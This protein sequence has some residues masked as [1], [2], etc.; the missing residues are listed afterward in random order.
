MYV[1][2]I[3][4]NCVKPLLQFLRF[5]NFITI[6]AI[7][8]EREFLLEMEINVTTESV[9]SLSSFNI[10]NTHHTVVVEVPI[11]SI[12]I[13]PKICPPAEVFCQSM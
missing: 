13:V 7:K 9:P 4:Y 6:N 8:L 2:D 12:S 11:C 3:I 5:V 10:Y 1:S